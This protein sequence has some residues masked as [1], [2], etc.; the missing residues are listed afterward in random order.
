M[1]EHF[2]SCGKYHAIDVRRR[3]ARDNVGKWMGDGKPDILLANS[4]D[5]SERFRWYN[6]APVK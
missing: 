5:W 1:D 6:P 2:C 3:S 4:T